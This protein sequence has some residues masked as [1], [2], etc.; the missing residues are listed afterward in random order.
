LS[1]PL[2]AA[3][4]VVAGAVIEGMVLFLLIDML[5]EAGAVRK[6]FQGIDIPVGTGLSFP[7][8][9][10][11]IFIGYALFSWYDNSYHL[12]I[13]GLMSISFL[14]FIDDM[15]GQ[16][17]T[18]GFKG[19]I[20]SLLHG[21]LTTG[22]LKALGGGMIAL[23]LALFASTGWIN[24]IVNTIIMALFTNMLNL[25]DLRP[26]RAV[27]GFL[28]FLL[29][30][31]LLAGGKIN[32][33]L[34]SPLIGG[35]LYYFRFDLKALT[36]MGDSGSNV[37]GLALGFITITSLAL[38]PRLG[39][40]FFLVAIHIYTEKYSLTETINKVYILR[41]IDEMGRRVNND[42]QG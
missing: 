14:G 21:K 36:M 30:I 29:V 27:K 18:L 31:V 25:L 38:V 9:V 13:L 42:Q 23:F 22:G 12:F 16:R 5:K 40:L 3:L 2:T 15:L 37:L 28:F 24:I 4:A 7:M 11:L 26:G 32:W 8:T 6:N 10:M 1:I 39:V 19:H 41:I 33:L 17:D 20:G 35:V 34:V